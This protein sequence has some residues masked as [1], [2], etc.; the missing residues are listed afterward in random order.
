MLL[1]ERQRA[2]NFLGDLKACVHSFQAHA[3]RSWLVLKERK[4][5]ASSSS[6]GGGVCLCREE[7]SACHWRSRRMQ[8]GPSDRCRAGMVIGL[9]ALQAVHAALS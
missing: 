8:V 1:H 3:G 5:W 7:V 9:P 6:S 2:E 4:G